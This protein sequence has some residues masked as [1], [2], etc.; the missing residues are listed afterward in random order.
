MGGRPHEQSCSPV[1]V[2]ASISSRPAWTPLAAQ[3]RRGLPA[4]H[5]PR[6]TGLWRVAELAGGCWALP[7]QPRRG[8][9]RLWPATTVAAG[10]A[11]RR[12]EVSENKIV[13]SRDCK[14]TTSGVPIES[15]EQGIQH[16]GVQESTKAFILIQ[17][18]IG[19]VDSLTKTTPYRVARG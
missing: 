19:V 18:D 11:C 8:S 2:H 16:F 13:Y 3:R 12:A 17:K 6:A 10:S 5:Q 4:A 15:L 7:L 14:R 1:R 9:R